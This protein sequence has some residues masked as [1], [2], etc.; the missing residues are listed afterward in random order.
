[1]GVLLLRVVLVGVFLLLVEDS[2]RAILV[3]MVFQVAR[4]LVLKVVQITKGRRSYVPRC[5]I[6]G[7]EYYAD[8][9]PQFLSARQAL[10]SA[11]LAQAF[12]S[13]C[14]I[15]TLLLIGILTGYLC[16]YDQSDLCTEFLQVLFW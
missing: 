6:C 5:Q 14:N 10:P 4:I 12:T 8:K 3:G 13:S 9:C 16:S 11:N 2:L 15:S 7:G 1:M